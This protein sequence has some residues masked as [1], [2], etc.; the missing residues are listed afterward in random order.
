MRKQILP[1]TMF[2]KNSLPESKLANDP[3]FALLESLPEEAL[4]I[5]P[6]GIILTANTLFAARFSISAEEC[7]GAAVYDLIATIL[8][9]PEQAVHYKKKI[10]EVLHLGKRMVFEDGKGNLNWKFTINPVLSPEGT[11]TRLFITIADISRQKQKET[12]FNECKVKFNQALEAAR[13]GVWEWDLT[14]NDNIWSD[15]IW[16]LYGLE[17]TNNSPS[18]HLWASVIHPEDRDSVISAVTEAAKC[19]AEL[20]IEY[21]VCYPD[22]SMHWLMSRGKPLHDLNG[23]T[24]RYIGTI[25]DITKRKEFQERL[26]A[27]NERMHFILAATSSGTWEHDITTNTNIWS[28]E[29][30]SLCGLK[31]NSVE[32]NYE[33]WINTIIPEDRERVRQATIDAVNKGCEFIC[34]WRIPGA[35][36]AVRWLMSKGTPVKDSEGKIVRYAGIMID[37]TDQKQRD[38]ALKESENRF[39]MVF[40]KHSSIML[41]LEPDTG[42]IIDVNQAAV[43]FYKWPTETLKQMTIRQITT[44]P[45]E[46]RQNQTHQIADGSLRDVEVYSCLIPFGEKEILYAIM[47]DIT[48]RKKVEQALAVSEKKFRS[49]T[50]Q[51]SEIVF[52]TDQSGITTYVSPA[53]ETISGYKADEVIGHRFVEFMAEEDI[54]RAISSFQNGL[55]MQVDEVLEF[56]YRK[57]DRSLFYAEIHVQFY[58]HEGFIGYIGLIRDITER[59]KYEQELIE[60]RQLLKSIY[61]QVNYAIFVVD[62]LTD[63]TYRYNSINPLSEQISGVTSNEL[64]GKRPEQFFPPPIAKSVI[65]HYNDCI[66]ENKII[67]YEESM[68]F[69][70]KSSL[71]E[72]V[73]NPVRNENGAIFRIIGTS[74][75]ITERRQ[76][77]EQRTEL[78]VQLQQSQKMEMVGRL[79]G[80]IAHDFNNMLTVILGHSEMAMETSDPTLKTYAQFIAIHQA[81]T[82]SAN[83]TRQLLAFARKQVVSPKIVEL[84]TAITEMLPMLRRLIGENIM[85]TW[86]PECKNCY[87]KIDPSQIDQILVNLCI[88]ARDAI[89]G[90]GRITIDN[91]CVTLPEI[92]CETDKTAC[93]SADYVSLS[94][95]DDGCGIEPNDLQHIFE[96]FFTTKESGKGTG[97]GLST[98]YGIVKQNNGNIECQSEQGKGTTITI[99]LPKHMVQAITNPDRDQKQLL[100]KGHQTILLV[101]DEPGILKL[102]KLILEQNGYNVLAFERAADAI[103]MEKNYPGTIDLLVTDVI[104]PEMNGAEL[105]KRLLA[106]RPEL[107]VL[108]ISGYTADIIPQNTIVDSQLNFIQKPF[109]PKSL[110]TIIYNI[111]N[112][113]LLKTP[114]ME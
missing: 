103:R 12:R 14:T 97:L 82:H 49:I 9:I 90:N 106:A 19:D 93:H 24:L 4:L 42:R 39:R 63:G 61:N 6:N 3:V 72:T 73:L 91:R 104:M 20:N 58:K 41:V 22:G 60:S 8:Q 77:E 56:R 80:G 107:N 68:M 70:G 30:W 2:T 105:S 78:S 74:V 10:G 76:I 33:S 75:D 23:R 52:I 86:I 83:L 36:G 34:S 32:L 47:N 85:L 94:V 55:M 101:E 53:V 29:I 44:E 51:I 98:V 48:E 17:S 84:N 69:H 27:A 21:R 28:D 57:K 96:P 71:W 89:T 13:A 43:N 108:F 7:I 59:K 1:I 50:E 99:Q 67:H 88:N 16:P 109:N 35:D 31:P 18:F 102:C 5:D 112:P 40:E 111:L 79:A 11:I 81:A 25:I 65:Q 26:L 64:A 100:K 62:I 110:T 66:R 46:S 113:K 114:V 37:I 95:H 54:E 38:D 87:I 15:E 45:F 92:P